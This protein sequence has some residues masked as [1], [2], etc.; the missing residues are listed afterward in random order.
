[1]YAIKSIVRNANIN[2]SDVREGFC[3]SAIVQVTQ[4][5]TWVSFSTWNKSGCVFLDATYGPESRLYHSHSN[6]DTAHEGEKYTEVDLNMII[7][8]WALKELQLTHISRNGIVVPLPEDP[9]TSIIKVKIGVADDFKLLAPSRICPKLFFMSSASWQE[10]QFAVETSKMAQFWR[11]LPLEL[12]SKSND[13]RLEMLHSVDRIQR[14]LV[15]TH[16]DTTQKYATLIVVLLLVVVYAVG[17]TFFMIAAL[18][19]IGNLFSEYFAQCMTM[20][21]LQFSVLSKDVIYCYL[22][23]F[24]SSVRI[25]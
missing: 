20:R 5:A 9:E 25:E 4:N 13:A 3:L 8:M 1:M 12:I 23:R 19:F 14:F 15:F 7:P 16:P 22:W 18:I 6:M 24:P 2:S 10:A 21:V 17:P 11:S